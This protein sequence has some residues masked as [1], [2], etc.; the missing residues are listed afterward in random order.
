MEELIPA[1][2]AKYRG[3]GSR[4]RYLTG[5][6]SG[7]WSSIWLQ[8][9]YPDQF[10]GC[11]A[12]CPDPVDFRDFQRVN[13]YQP[14]SSMFVDESGARRP[15][16]RYQDRVLLFYDDFVQREEVLGSG[17]QIACFEA[18][19]SP[20]GKD[21]APRR[22]FDRRTG[23][24]DSDIAKTWERFDIRL[25]LERRW[26][27][28]KDRLAGKLHIYAGEK[29]TFYLEGAVRLL[30]ESLA[31]LGSDAE[32]KIVAGMSHG[33]YEEANVEMYRS[34]VAES[35]KSNR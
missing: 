23:G 16:A 5:V 31:A 15:I 7:G 24:V 26:K 18:M 14:G 11:W 17:G 6:S 35:D 27:D 22:V 2:E 32:V 13:L 4:H 29:D 21:G 33:M 19:F 20:R 30:K 28:L 25:V 3:M 1:V 12:H 10:N 8:V 9:N 34:I